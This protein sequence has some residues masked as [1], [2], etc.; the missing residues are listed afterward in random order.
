LSLGVSDSYSFD[1]TTKYEIPYSWNIAL[2]S[3]EVI[4]NSA[5]LFALF[6]IDKSSAFFFV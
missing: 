5:I 1:L 4:C 6:S 2:C 3:G